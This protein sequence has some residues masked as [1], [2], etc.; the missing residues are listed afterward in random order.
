MAN[1]K[2]FKKIS[3]TIFQKICIHK[4]VKETSLTD[5]VID[6]LRRLNSERLLVIGGV[7]EG[8]NG[9]D[10]EW[11]IVFPGN[12]S[13]GPEVVHL[14]IQAKRLYLGQLKD[15]YY[16]E[17][18]HNKG[19][20][21]KDL[22]R[23]SNKIGAIPLYCFY[24]YYFKTKNSLQKDPI[25]ADDGWR[26][27]YASNI[28]NVRK[29]GLST[30]NHLS[31][32]DPLTYPMHWIFRLAE[33][34]PMA[35]VLQYMKNDGS[36]PSTQLVKNELPNYV[37]DALDD[38]MYPN[39]NFFKNKDWFPGIKKI[40]KKSKAKKGKIAL[41]RKR[42]ILNGVMPFCH[43]EKKPQPPLIITIAEEPMHLE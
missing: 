26:Y 27:A 3:E 31:T 4:N 40:R 5:E 20:Q 12:A 35:I 30:F 42:P 11:W 14:R 19:N 28:S 38:Y 8:K 2:D 10:I 23:E 15:H 37:F 34:N 13:H 36:V 32:I 7:N 25:A 22:V 29:K 9:A 43:L 1:E 21:L 6:Q 16:K 18:D 39:G 41:K 24:N 33:K 17:L